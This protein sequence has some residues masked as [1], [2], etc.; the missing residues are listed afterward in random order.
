MIF[1]Q[2]KKVTTFDYLSPNYFQNTFMDKI[3]LTVQKRIVTI[4]IILFV[5]KLAAY[6]LTNSVGILTDALESTV[7]VITGLVSLYSIGLALKPKDKGHPF[8]HGK[9]ELLSASLEGFL[10]FLAGLII[11][12][13]AVKRFF[14]PAEIQQL[15]IGIIIIAVAGLI[16]YVVGF[17][18][19]KTGRKHNSAALVAG[20]KHL[21]SDTYSSIG[22]VIGLI[23]LMITR[24]AWLDSLIAIIFGGIIIYTGLKIMKETTS[25]LMDEA[26]FKI[27]EAIT[28]IIYMHRTK[29]WVNIHNVKMVRYGNSYHLDCDLTLPWYMNVRE[30]HVEIDHLQEVV[31]NGYSE[32]VDL[33]IHTDACTDDLCTNCPK[34]DCSKRSH[35]FTFELPWTV[36]QII[37]TKTQL[38][39]N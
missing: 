19:I 22:L 2:L 28:L 35:D 8:G 5:G 13:E 14:I 26:D 38:Q 21:Q 31:K 36:E 15:D 3:K 17:Y 1:N 33:T 6:Y 23:L 16:N 7:N 10:I 29:N 34:S 18:S 37:K 9:V 4:S 11:I 39:E 32:S 24:L 20:G 30:A 27:I 12:F 25:V